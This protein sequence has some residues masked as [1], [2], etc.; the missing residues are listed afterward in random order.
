MQRRQ[1]SGAGCWRR[2]ELTDLYRDRRGVKYLTREVP[3][4]GLP[5]SAGWFPSGRYPSGSANGMRAPVPGPAIGLAR[6]VAALRP[7]SHLSVWR[8]GQSA[9]V[10]SPGAGEQ[11]RVQPGAEFDEVLAADGD[12]PVQGLTGAGHNVTTSQGVVAG[13]IGGYE[14]GGYT[15]AVSYLTQFT[16]NVSALYATAVAGG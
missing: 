14:Q 11:V 16:S 12:V 10:S 15:P 8:P 7:A 5:V 9:N 1:A 6:R 3:G 13:V 4:H 2:A